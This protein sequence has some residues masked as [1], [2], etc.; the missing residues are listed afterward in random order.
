MIIAKFKEGG[1]GDIKFS[2]ND[3][4]TQI[5]DYGQVPEIVNTEYSYKEQNLDADINFNEQKCDF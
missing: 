4:L 5:Y 1:I 2:H 3:S